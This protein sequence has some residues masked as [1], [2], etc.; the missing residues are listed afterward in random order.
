MGL[1]KI[2]GC[3]KGR[4]DELSIGDEKNYEGAVK[5]REMLRPHP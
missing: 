1:L 5:N 4:I 2:G 3:W